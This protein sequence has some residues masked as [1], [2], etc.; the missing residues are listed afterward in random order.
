M[1]YVSFTLIRTHKIARSRCF[2]NRLSTQPLASSSSPSPS[3]SV[4]ITTVD[5]THSASTHTPPVSWN[6]VYSIWKSPSEYDL[7]P[8]CP[9]YPI[10]TENCIKFFIYTVDWITNE[11]WI[12][13]PTKLPNF[14]SLMSPRLVWGSL[15]L[16]SNGY[17]GS[18]S[19]R[20]VHRVWRWT[21]TSVWCQR[22]HRIILSLPPVSTWRAA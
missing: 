6:L 10:S 22:T 17:R 15:S 11:S 20:E 5:P 7:L 18:F 1:S 3:T 14:Y 12:R 2:Q 16:L 4:P 19:G 9:E 21:V 13:F 8:F